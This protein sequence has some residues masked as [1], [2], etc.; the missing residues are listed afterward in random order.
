[1]ADFSGIFGSFSSG[2]GKLGIIAQ[3][4]FY[5]LLIGAILYALWIYLS[6]NI[7]VGIRVRSGEGGYITTWKKGKFQKDKTNPS[8]QN[9]LIMGD[10]R[11]NFPLDRSYVEVIRKAFGRIGYQVYF[12]EDEKGRIQPIKTVSKDNVETW[13]GWSPESSEFYLRNMKEIIDRFKKGDW[14][15]KYAPFIYI[16]AF[17]MIF[18]LGIVLFRQMADISK[19]LGAIAEVLRQ[20]AIGFGT[21]VATN[22][23]Q[24]ITG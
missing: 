8:T 13:K 17:A 2:L 20:A 3:Y 4:V 18:I 21:A 19:Q 14:F 24:V 5:G 9:F 12:I 11:W 7:R 22:G 16:A 1:M 6:Y 23:T 15:T 10:K